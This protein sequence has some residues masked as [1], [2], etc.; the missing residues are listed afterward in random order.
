MSTSRIL[1]ADDDQTTCLLIQAALVKAGLVVELAYDG[2]QALAAF[3]EGLFDMV[4][5]DVD[6]PGM[7]GF[8]VCAELR[9][10]H[11][12]ELP[13]VMVTG[14]D[15]IASI[16]AAFDAGATDFIAKPLPWPLLAHR[17]RYVLRA[18]R[19]AAAL[20][21]ANARN[22][23]LLAALPD[24]L[25]RID[26]NNDIVE[27][28][29]APADSRPCCTPVVG[30]ALAAVFPPSAN[31]V[32]ER[33][34]AETRKS[35]QSRTVEFALASK[36]GRP[37]H[38]EARM[39]AIDG[40]EVLCLLR[41]ITERKEYES[42]IHR[43][44]YFDSLTGLANRRGFLERL[45]REIRRAHQ[46]DWRLA[47]LFLD[48]DRFKSINDTLG[49]AAGDRLLQQAAERLRAITRPGDIVSHDADGLGSAE[50]AR[51]GGD[52]FTV[53]LP[54]INR[55]E[56]ALPIAERIRASLSTP[57]A[58][59]GQPLSLTTS[60][61]IAIF[62]DDGDDAATLIKHADTAMYDAKARGRNS[63]R[64]YNPTLTAEAV[65]RVALEAGLR[66][67]LARE[68]FV[69]LY[70]PQIE[71]RSGRIATV[72]ALVRWQPPGGGLVSPLDFI[73]L[74]EECGLIDA[75]GAWVLQR[76]CR[77]AARWRAHGLD[78]RVAVNLSPM[79]FRAHDLIGT[80]RA[81]L[82]A[83]AMPASHLELE[84]T[85]NALMA[86]DAATHG[87][88]GALRELGIGIALDDFGTGYSS[89]SYLKRLP[90]C[91]LKI[92]RSFIHGLPDD[93]DNLAI[94]HAILA[95]ARHLGFSITAEGVETAAQAALLGEL[96]ADSL[97]GY[98]FSRPVPAVEIE[99]LAHRQWPTYGGAAFS[100][101]ADAGCAPAKAGPPPA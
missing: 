43:L 74:A 53:L 77:D 89:L 15:D 87:T 99:A 9:R 57:F 79:Q 10:R 56:D 48:L 82:A 24:T 76:A 55:P 1:V 35:R 17:V 81:A 2:A 66:R 101:L 75:I 67:A 14:M 31:A 21:T 78:L 80:V 36:T 92:D 49:H 29:A 54:M 91:R 52:E 16:E 71:A 59:G 18:T 94:V 46:N 40:S 62:P 42:R 70:Q 65:H 33:A 19:S 27:L 38:R 44:A 95:L 72:E 96:E 98:L 68:E 85:E 6:M 69:L 58:I 26:G 25:M 61:G 23:A 32:L 20:R 93:A 22:A 60:I 37:S 3:D 30:K 11:G 34:L 41:D 84:I 90:L 45:E 86:D 63:C 12:D 13:I 28:H 73:P 97:Q 39:S 64:Y 51:L 5:L 100:A 4:M 50:F 88:L 47:V 7:N 83:S 8:A